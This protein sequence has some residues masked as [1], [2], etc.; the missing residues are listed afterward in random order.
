MQR[1]DPLLLPA[2]AVPGSFRDAVALT[3]VSPLCSDPVV[4]LPE[5]IILRGERNCR[6]Q[7]DGEWRLDKDQ[8]VLCGQWEIPAPA[9]ARAFPM[10]PPSLARMERGSWGLGGLSGM[11]K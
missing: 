6:Q 4:M 3:I 11:V 1:G 5:A 8:S 7:T 10:G 2:P 9:D